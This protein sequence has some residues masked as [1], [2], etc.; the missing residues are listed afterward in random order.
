[1]AFSWK[2]FLR[3]GGKDRGA[4]EVICLEFTGVPGSRTLRVTSLKI[5]GREKGWP[6][7]LGARG[8]SLHEMFGTWPFTPDGRAALRAHSDK[9]PYYGWGYVK[10]TVRIVQRQEN[11]CTLPGVDQDLARRIYDEAKAIE[12]TPGSA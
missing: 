2:K 5:S 12:G 3:A 11:G 7:L 9:V 6:E 10:E 1:M 4:G 8:P